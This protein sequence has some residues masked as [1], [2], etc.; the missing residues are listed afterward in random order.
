MTRSSPLECSSS[1]RRL[2][3][4]ARRVPL[5]AIHGDVD[6]IV[7]AGQGHSIWSGFFQSEAL[8]AFVKAHARP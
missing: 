2:A 4:A 8:V 1:R 5:F 7:P 3:L 6:R